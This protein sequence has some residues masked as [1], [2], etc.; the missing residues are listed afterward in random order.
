MFCDYA[1]SFS[2]WKIRMSMG[3]NRWRHACSFFSAA[4]SYNPL[5]A[6]V[7]IGLYTSHE[8][9]SIIVMGRAPRTS[10][11]LTHDLLCFLP[12]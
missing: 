10:I 12:S 8:I 7:L 1:P 11:S 4:D 9:Y 6:V 2:D 5:M 3:S